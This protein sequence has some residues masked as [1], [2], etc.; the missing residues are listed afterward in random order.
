MYNNNNNNNNKQEVR[1]RSQNPSNIQM[2][3]KY[4]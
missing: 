2:E 1:N 4:I 3:L